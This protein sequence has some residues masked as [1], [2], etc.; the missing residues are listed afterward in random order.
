M[1][2]LEMIETIRKR[3]DISYEEADRM[4]NEAEGDALAVLVR[5]EKMGKLKSQQGCDTDKAQTGTSAE[6]TFEKEGR[7]ENLFKKTI[8]VGGRFLAHTKLH[9]I[10]NENELIV[11]PSFVFAILMVFFWETILPVVL[12]SLLFNVHYYFD[13]EAD[14]ERANAFFDRAEDVAEEIKQPSHHEEPASEE[15]QHDSDIAGKDETC[16]EAVG[17]IEG[18]F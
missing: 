13:G 7:K 2:R 9:I 8:R 17:D 4:L 5:L 16:P 15:M 18:S 10:H 12:I 11:M 6:P 14:V 3:A 1:N